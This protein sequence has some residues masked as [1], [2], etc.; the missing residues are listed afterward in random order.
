MDE[1]V[2]L[3]LRVVTGLAAAALVLWLS[4]KIIRATLQGAGALL[5]FA[6]Q[7][8]FLGLI[9]YVAAWVFMLPVMLII[10]F[11]YGILLRSEEKQDMQEWEDFSARLDERKSL[12][13]PEEDEA[14]ERR[15]E[16]ARRERL[17]TLK[18]MQE[19]ETE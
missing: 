9:A 16:Q 3:I 1:P 10:S 19:Q 2:A 6:S 14:W 17:E 12:L 11:G 18:R 7:Q 4:W 8:Q 15:Y 13:P 5:E